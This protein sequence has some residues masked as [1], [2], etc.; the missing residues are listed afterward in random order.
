[1]PP[2]PYS[3]YVGTIAT[4]VGTPPGGAGAT[5]PGGPSGATGPTGP[6]GSG[7]TGPTGATGAGGTGATGP[8]GP[9][10]LVS[11]GS[12]TNGAPVVLTGALATVAT[13]T[14]TIVAGQSVIL[15][16]YVSAAVAG[17]VSGGAL[18]LDIQIDGVSV[19]GGPI[20]Q[21]YAGGSTG[22]SAAFATEVGPAA[23]SRVLTVKAAATGDG[24]LTVGTGGGKLMRQVVVV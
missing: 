12:S 13:A 6:A 9:A 16:G 23:G 7:A 2:I 20:E 10:N 5:G 1:M 17:S 24:T 22:V 21:G 18:E 4:S 8:T 15:T 19:I 14:I 3:T 11:T